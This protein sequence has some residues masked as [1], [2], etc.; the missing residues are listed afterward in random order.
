MIIL[1]FLG[2]ILCISALICLGADFLHFWDLDQW[3][4]QELGLVW[5]NLSPGSL[6][7]SQAIIQRYLLASL[8]DP[9]IVTLL[10]QPAWAVLGA[11]GVILLYL[12]RRS[13]LRNLNRRLFIRG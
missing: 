12:A 5:Y 6:N 13:R 11:P 1:R 3:K 10:L 7:F 2:W 8:W 4:A 9:V